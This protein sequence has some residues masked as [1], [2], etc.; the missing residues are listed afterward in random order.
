MDT[1]FDLQQG[2]TQEPSGFATP[3]EKANAR[4]WGLQAAKYIWHN[5]HSSGSR[6]FYQPNL[7]HS[8]ENYS[9]RDHDWLIDLALG[10]QDPGIYKPFLGVDPGENEVKRNFIGAMRWHIKNYATKRVNIA[11]E[12]V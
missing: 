7:G 5:H 3:K 4:R 12:K 11:K 9:E 6:L 10:K 2:H 1:D 8:V